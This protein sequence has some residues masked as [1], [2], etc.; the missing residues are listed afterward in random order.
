MVTTR[1]QA[2]RSELLLM[3][4]RLQRLHNVHRAHL[5]QLSNRQIVRQK[6]QTDA[7]GSLGMGRACNRHHR[8]LSSYHAKVHPASWSQ[9]LEVLIVQIQIQAQTCTQSRDWSQST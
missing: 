9:S 4:T 3:S 8:R 5:L 7:H 6:L 1:I 2:E